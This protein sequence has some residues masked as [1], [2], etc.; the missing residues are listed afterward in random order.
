MAKKSGE[1]SYYDI[2]D[3]INSLKDSLSKSGFTQKEFSLKLD[4]MEINAPA[5]GFK[6]KVSAKLDITLQNRDIAK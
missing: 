3:V 5:L 1:S 6:M 2:T 4:D